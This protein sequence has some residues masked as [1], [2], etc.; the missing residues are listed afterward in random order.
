MAT[1][2]GTQD[3]QEQQMSAVTPRQQSLS[4]VMLSMA[5]GYCRRRRSMFA[6]Q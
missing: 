2:T 6:G 3:R 1:I 5:R 4:A